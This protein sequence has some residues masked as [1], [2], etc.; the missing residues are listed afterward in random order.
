MWV[1]PVRASRPSG[2]AC[3][4]RKRSSSGG[5]AP[6]PWRGTRRVASISRAMAATCA[7]MAAE[8]E[9]L[10]APA[11]GTECARGERKARS[12]RRLV[13]RR[14]SSTSR[15]S[16][17]DEHS[18]ARRRPPRRDDATFRDTDPIARRRHC[19][20]PAEERKGR[21]FRRRWDSPRSCQCATVPVRASALELGTGKGSG[22]WR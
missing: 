21:R 1:S 18:H 7:E 14:E 3:G 10:A 22:G 17:A 20:R 15:L 5:R 4:D 19:P 2:S 11:A 13:E 12:A 6:P 8:E 9:R 16:S